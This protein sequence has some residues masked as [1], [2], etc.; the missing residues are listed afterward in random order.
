MLG[1]RRRLQAQTDPPAGNE[2]LGAVIAAEVAARTAAAELWPTVVV[3]RERA[4]ELSVVN[5]ARDL[6]CGVLSLLP[7]TRSTVH[8]V[9]M[10]GDPRPLPVGWLERPDPTR[11][12]GAFV[13]A[14]VDDLF[15]EG[16][17]AAR[18]TSR[19]ADGTPNALKHYPWRQLDPPRGH[20]AR[21]DGA[22]EDGWWRYTP[23]AGVGERF[24]E[25]NVV[26][27]E[28]PLVGVLASPLGLDIAARLAV[29]ARRFASSTVPMG[30][31]EQK[32]G[33]A[34]LT[35]DE[36]SELAVS[37]ADA[38]ELNAIAALNEAVEYH[39]SQLDPSRMQLVEARA[40]QDAALAR[41][42]NVP[43][44]MVGASTPGDSMTYRTALSARWDLI[45]FGLAPYIGA[46]TET[47]SMPDVT[48]RGQIIGMDPAPFLHATE[49]AGERQAQTAPTEAVP[50]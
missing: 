22:G 38:R 36:L 28:S 25:L 46:I 41:Y 9:P 49:L 42:C 34:P 43:G 48:P 23:A 50:R 39:E 14:L 29:A 45:D 44:F 1:R 10:G 16:W 15:F 18:I 11:T 4:L 24:L 2:R 8:G 3:S 30:W 47:L 20:P 40:Y 32:A 33:S 31:L 7:F 13:A 35:V 6:V 12:R 26:T 37:F 21:R 5:R 19:D 27:F 17:A